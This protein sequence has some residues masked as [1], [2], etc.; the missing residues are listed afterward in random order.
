VTPWAGVR[1]AT[2]PRDRCP[3]TAS[4]GTPSAT[5]DCLYL[6]VTTPSTPGRKP[7]M[8][9][10]HG[11]GNSI[12]AGSDF[13]ATRLA[14]Q[15]DVVVVTVN[16]RLGVFSAFSHPDQAGGGAFGLEDQQAALRWVR[17]NATAFGGDPGRV[18]LFGESGGAFDVCAQLTS[19]GARGL[20]QRAIIQSGTCSTSWPANGL[21]HGQPAA[22]S[23]VSLAESNAHGADLA[24]EYGC[25]DSAN[26]VD[27]LRQV[28]AADL[29]SRDYVMLITRLAYGTKVL[30]SRPDQALA[31]GRFHRRSRSPRS[32]TRH[33]WSRRS[34]PTR[35]GWRP[36][37]RP[38]STARRSSRTRRC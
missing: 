22:S 25:A 6:N 28:P 38:P 14:V 32:P 20:F 13:D 26:A 35:R 3:Q 29:V 2:S 36:S 10:V 23:F 8:V 21:A 5:E 16:Y 37:T 9:W 27:C 33:C 31:Q 11:G 1:D 7:V 24:A 17:R 19:P 12:G 18:T 15:G 34:A 4:G 30:P